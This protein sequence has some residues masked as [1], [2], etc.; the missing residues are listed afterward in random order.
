MI[1]NLKA[2]SGGGNMNNST[3]VALGLLVAAVLATVSI[4]AKSKSAV[5]AESKKIVLTA[6]N[7]IILND[8]IDGT[9][10]AEVIS[11]AKLLDESGM[12][13]RVGVKKSAPIYLFLRTPGGEIQ[14]GLEM[15]EALQ[16]LNRPVDTVTMFAASMGF[17]TAQNLGKRLIVKNGIMMSHRAR[18]GFEGEF[19]GQ[20]P[21]QMDS[22]KNLWETRMD[23]MD[24]QTVAR[25]N[26]K[27]TLESY[28]KAYASELWV[29]GSQ[30]VEQGYA[31]EVVSVKCDESL[32]G[33]TTKS[34][35]LFG[36]IN[37]DYDLDNCPLN[38]SPMNIRVT[39][40]V[41]TKGTKTLDNF[42]SEGGEFGN[43]CLVAYGSNPE[44]L[45]AV[46]TTLTLERINQ[47]KVQFKNQ[48]ENIK[49]RTIPLGK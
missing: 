40:I 2:H 28:Q 8:A 49:E 13:G 3:K 21:S 48:Y 46:D 11:K 9:S 30:A 47:L 44:K 7:T 37:I 36:L 10:V 42:L 39:K 31:D 41:T 43:S 33:V 16:G 5:S 34:I 24:K 15:L 20:R 6:D 4:D 32:S 19:G 26:G 23:E 25:S 12:L 18:G 29:T 14:M 17:Q 38:S 1:Y 35:S 27:Q 22:R 45:C